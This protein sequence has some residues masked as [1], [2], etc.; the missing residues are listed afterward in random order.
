MTVRYTDFTVSAALVRK[1]PISP[2]DVGL[3]N[4][5]PNVWESHPSQT[6]IPYDSANKNNFLSKLILLLLG[7]SHPW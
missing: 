6:R 2:T 1:N 4:T 3:N 7:R 5:T